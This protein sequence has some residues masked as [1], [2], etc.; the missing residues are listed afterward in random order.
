MQVRKAKQI[1]CTQSISFVCLLANCHNKVLGCFFFWYFEY[2]FY[3][4][5]WDVCC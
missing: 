1:F 5:T 2:F 4:Y 3:M